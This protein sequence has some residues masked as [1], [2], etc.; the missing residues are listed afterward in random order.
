M[1]G[2]ARGARTHARAALAFATIFATGCTSILGQISVGEQG[3]ADSGESP[4]GSNSDAGEG[5]TPMEASA[6]DA[7][8]GD[9]GRSDSGPHDSGA[10]DSGPPDVGPPGAPGYGL[11]AGA[12]VMTSAGFKIYGVLGES[13]GG[14]TVSKS[15]SYTLRGGVIGATK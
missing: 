8:A 7:D 13:P 14:N 9:S 12:S 4:D 10:H 1:S 2:L 6:G 5:G 11:S 15:G 3:G